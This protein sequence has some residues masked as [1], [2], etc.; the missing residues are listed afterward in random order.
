MPSYRKDR[1]ERREFREGPPEALRRGP[2]SFRRELP[3]GESPFSSRPIPPEER[4]PELWE[5]LVP[6]SERLDPY[7][8][9]AENVFGI[10]A[11]GASRT[12][13]PQPTRG[14]APPPPRE[15]PRPARREPRKIDPHVLNSIWGQIGA[16]RRDSRFHPGSPVAVLQVARATKDEAARVNDLVR[17]FPDLGQEVERYRGSQIWRDIVDPYLE[18]LAY[19]I[20]YQKPRELPGR[21]LFQSG[22]DG[23]FWLAYTE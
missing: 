16:L 13:E 20:N 8:N 2:T 11:P 15:A 17:F 10:V 4:T 12:A 3:E 1:P 9:Y 19:S 5:I 18:D 22:R 6:E 21:V 23:S 7:F 14:Q